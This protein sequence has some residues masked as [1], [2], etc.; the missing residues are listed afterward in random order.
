MKVALVLI[1]SVIA[2][3]ADLTAWRQLHFPD[4]VT[5]PS[6]EAAVWGNLANPDA[7]EYLNLMEY[8]QQTDPNT[9][10]DPLQTGEVTIDNELFLT[11][12]FPHDILNPNLAT[13]VEWST[14]ATNWTP[15]V[16][17]APT[18]EVPIASTSRIH[19]RA[20]NGSVDWVTVRTAQPV[21]PQQRGFLRLTVAPEVEILPALADAMPFQIDDGLLTDPILQLPEATSVNVVWYTSFS[22]S[23]HRLVY[24]DRLD[25][26]ASATSIRLSRMLEDDQSELRPGLLSELGD[27]TASGVRE[28]S[29]W[30]H[31]AKAIG[32]SVGL[33]AP[34][35]VESVDNQG[36]L[37]RSQAYSLQP[38]P[39]QNQRVRILL[40]SD[41]QNRT[42]SAANYQKVA[43]TVGTPDAIF[44]AGDFVDYPNRASEWFDRDST[45]RPAFYPALQGRWNQL[46]PAGDYQGGALLQHAALFGTLGNHEVS[47]RW[48]PDVNNINTMYNDPQ[49]AWYATIRY[50]DY[51]DWGNPTDPHYVRDHSFETITYDEMW[52]SANAGAPYWSCLYG[53]VFVI[54]LHVN[55]IWRLWGPNRKGKEGE[56]PADVNDPDRW[57]FG[58]HLFED[59]ESGSAQYQWL[60]DTLASQEFLDAKYRVV[61]AH[62]TMFGL[63]DNVYPVLDK[64]EAEILY[65]DGTGPETLKVTFPVP[66]ATWDA[67]IAPLLGSIISIQY[68]YEESGDLW[69]NEIEPLL[70]NAGVHLV[71]TGHSHLWNRSIV[72]G[73]HYLETSNV[74]NSFGARYTDGSGTQTW[75]PD[76]FPTGDPHGRP[77]V[78][79]THFNPMQMIEGY[80]N[81]LPFVSSNRLTVFS[82]LDTGDG[83][84]KSYV[85]DTQ[86]PES[87]VILMDQFSLLP[88]P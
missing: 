54:S 2:A 57:G 36:Q 11:L 75:P 8:I 5:D 61:I 6:K 78:A 74:G 10:T 84:V 40:T 72:N 37:Y 3:R 29:I 45:S 47:G 70:T 66:E 81:P 46:N 88:L 68:T 31:E 53:D 77:A 79:P 55:R 16:L 33:R 9:F 63:G 22:G 17:L 83:M 51:L 26:Q 80:T 7:D 13:L 15:G 38:K 20:A 56:A 18:L 1:V 73:M 67:Q 49:P 32:L 24:G 21:H 41:Q 48:M 65:D 82:I 86:D 19:S 52:P 85:F 76:P 64:P 58:D 44:F 4:D 87:E 50:G 27:P 42:L 23:G 28:R 35:F 39:A 14:D 60:V 62:Q 69:R 59:F 12:S 25:Q 43:E 71:L 30:K 34:Y